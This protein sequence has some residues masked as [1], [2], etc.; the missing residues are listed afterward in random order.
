MNSLSGTTTLKSDF[1][2]WVNRLEEDSF[3]NAG[4]AIGSGP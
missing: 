3:F 4:F 2:G 1:V